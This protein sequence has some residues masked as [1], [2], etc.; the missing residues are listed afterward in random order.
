MSK[1]APIDEHVLGIKIYYADGSVVQIPVET[2]EHGWK[3]APEDGVQVVSIY[4]RE[5][6]L[7]R[8]YAQWFA[9]C[10]L[11]AYSPSLRAIIE[12]NRPSDLPLDAVIKTGSEM[13][14]TDFRALYN[15]AMNDHEF[16]DAGEVNPW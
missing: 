15:A 11:Y 1:V 8:Y 12:T 16:R 14:K 6:R 10:D 3:E 5:A 7:G 9:S 2:L 4:D 13:D